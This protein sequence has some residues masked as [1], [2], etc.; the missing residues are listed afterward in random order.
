MR[1]ILMCQDH[2]LREFPNA[3]NRLF[4]LPPAAPYVGTKFG[5]VRDKGHTTRPLP[6]GA[7]S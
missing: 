1:V 6:E 4:Y 7:A 3:A 5:N 2:D